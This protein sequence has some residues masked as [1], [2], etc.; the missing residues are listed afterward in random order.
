MGNKPVDLSKMLYDGRPHDMRPLEVVVNITSE[1]VKELGEHYARM[2][3]ENESVF[4]DLDE[5]PVQPEFPIPGDEWVGMIETVRDI[6]AVLEQG[7]QPSLSTELTARLTQVA[8]YPSPDYLFTLNAES[9]LTVVRCFYFEEALLVQAVRGLA[10]IL[11]MDGKVKLLRCAAPAPGRGSKKC[12]RFFI[13]G[14]KGG[15]PKKYCSNV[16]A[17][18]WGQR[19]RREREKEA[20]TT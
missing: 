17:R 11:C 8:R 2:R 6:V 7:E 18:R 12:G 15:R 9:V 14:G 5:K 16:C 13:S 20:E 10:D 3:G 19:K 1:A 4:A